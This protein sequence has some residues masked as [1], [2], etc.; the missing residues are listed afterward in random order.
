MN[1]KHTPPLPGGEYVH[2]GEPVTPPLP[3]GVKT[4]RFSAVGDGGPGPLLPRVTK[5]KKRKPVL[6]TL[7]E[8]AQLPR[9]ARVAFA[10]R[11]ALRVQ[12]L[13]QLDA[14]AEDVVGDAAVAIL[15]AATDPR[16]LAHFR[17]DFE[18]LMRLVKENGWTDGTPVSLEVFG[19]MW[20]KTRV[21]KWAK[22]TNKPQG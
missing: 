2:Q 3:P 20:P 15:R 7:D 22:E 11:C 14:G 4:V 18:R 13:V 5:S 16:D 10:N 1:P 21:P 17:R 8:I 12:P 6:P 9:L 19:P